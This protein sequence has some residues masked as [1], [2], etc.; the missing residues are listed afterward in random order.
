MTPTGF[1]AEA[2]TQAYIDSLGPEALERAAAY[3]TGNHWI[4]LGGLVVG[5]ITA[6][7]II[8][9]G[10]LSA[11]ERI[12]GERSNIGVFVIGLVYMLVSTIITLPWTI[13]SGW[14]REVQFDRTSQALGDYLTQSAMGTAIGAL[15]APLFL[16]LLYLFIRNARRTW[17]IWGGGLSAAAISLLMLLT[18]IYIMPLFNN[19][20]P[21]P[22]GEVR[23]A[24]EVMAIE[25]NIPTDRIFVFDGS[26]QSNNFT[27][28]VAG[29][30]PSARIAISDVA[31]GEASLDEVRAVTG[32]EIGHYVLGHIWYGIALVSVMSV[33]F[34]FL[35]S[36]LFPGL[37]GLFGAHRDIARASGLPVLIF[38]ISLLSTLA[39]PVFN[40]ASRWDETSAD[41]YSLDTVG[42]PDALATALV[43]TAEYRNPRPQGWE[44]VL[45]YTHPSV[46][47]RVRMAMEW[48]AENAA[49]GEAE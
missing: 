10:W 11:I 34:F 19:Y 48:K 31:L 4:M 26:R 23:D 30:G 35:A 20:E 37:A 43:K 18:P 14:W 40:T 13:Y 6:W 44:E 3:T 42:L 49:E 46:E 24:V 41:Q 32:H 17:W 22:D 36:W 12:F 7:L 25:A 29:I 33:V 21:L 47:R 5:A 1:D 16:V 27:A 39:S 28:N 2:A 8:R 45:F 38:F 15:I 9:L